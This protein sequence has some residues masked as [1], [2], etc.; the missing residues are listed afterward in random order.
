ME[1]WNKYT[2]TLPRDKPEKAEFASFRS[3]FVFVF[4]FAKAKTKL[5]VEK[6]RGIESGDI[7]TLDDI[8]KIPFTYKEE[9]RRWHEEVD[10]FPYGGLLGI[11]IEEV[12]TFRQTSG[13]TGNPVCVPE[14][15]ESWQW[16]IEALCHLLY[17]AGFRP[18]NRL[19]LPFGYNVYV[20]FWEC[21]YAAEKIGCEVIPWGPSIPG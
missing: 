14:S 19:F 11:P 2:E 21:H 12:S 15:Y 16:R 17:M 1:Y 3:L 9:Q 18:K 13:T 4:V 6:L 5:Y 10:P 7:K 8:K 20:A